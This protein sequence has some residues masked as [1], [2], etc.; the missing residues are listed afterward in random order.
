MSRFLYVQE[1]D[2]DRCERAL[3]AKVS[4]TVTGLSRDGA[5]ETV[6]GHIQSLRKRQSAFEGY[7]ALIVIR[8]N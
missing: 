5:A 2:L 1:K 8:P 6:S 4:I 3:L 7:P